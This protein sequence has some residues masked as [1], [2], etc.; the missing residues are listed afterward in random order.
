VSARRMAS[1]WAVLAER[2]RRT[3]SA[4]FSRVFSPVLSA[5]SKSATMRRSASR[6]WHSIISMAPAG[7]ALRARAGS[8]ARSWAAAA[9]ALSPQPSKGTWATAASISLSRSAS[10]S[11]IDDPPSI[12]G[13]FLIGEIA[14]HLLDEHQFREI[15]HAHGIEHS[16]QMVA[17]VLH[18]AGVES[19]GLPLDPLAFRRERAVDDAQAARNPARQSRHRKA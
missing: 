14:L 1:R 16:V 7:K 13:Q 5:C 11:L 17:L 19:T 15:R 4:T 6:L 3:A 9:S 10:V 2:R 8:M 12:L 18:H